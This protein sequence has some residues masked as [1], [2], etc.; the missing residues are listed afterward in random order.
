MAPTY[1]SQHFIGLHTTLDLVG[2][3]T[4]RSEGDHERL[5][6]LTDSSPFR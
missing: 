5:P 3:A 6:F 1:L 2:C 4:M